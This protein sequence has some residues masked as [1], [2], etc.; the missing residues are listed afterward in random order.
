MSAAKNNNNPEDNWLYKGIK[1]VLS[2]PEKIIERVEKYQ[3][4]RDEDV[5][6]CADILI[7]KKLTA[8][9]AYGVAAGAAGVIQVMGTIAAIACSA[10]VEFAAVTYLEMELC[11]ELAVLYGHDIKDEKRIY[12]MLA[13]KG[14]KRK[15][16]YADSAE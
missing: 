1:K 13:I 5:E 12:E 16:S 9:T 8:N 3:V 2:S 6:L 7:N 4:V 15:I 10:T 11:L 14:K